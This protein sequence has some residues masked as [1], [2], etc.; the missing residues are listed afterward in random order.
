MFCLGQEK[1]V[2]SD[3]KIGRGCECGVMGGDQ[4]REE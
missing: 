1:I 3:E 4:V 2:G